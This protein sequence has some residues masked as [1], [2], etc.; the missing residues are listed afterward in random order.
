MTRVT[1]SDLRSI[2]NNIRWLKRPATPEEL[3]K[4]MKYSDDRLQAN[5]IA[6]TTTL[7]CIGFEMGESNPITVESTLSWC[8]AVI[9]CLD[10]EE[11]WG[12]D[13]KLTKETRANLFQL[14]LGLLNRCF[15]STN[16]LSLFGLVERHFPST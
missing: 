9:D 6:L 3:L 1:S 11:G 14:S 4:V 8:R 15:T 16:A 13:H 10:F 2:V 7:A 12:M 5:R